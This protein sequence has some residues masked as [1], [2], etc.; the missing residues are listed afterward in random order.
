MQQELIDWQL[1]ID[2]TNATLHL[3]TNQGKALIRL[4]YNGNGDHDTALTTK[5]VL[6]KSNLPKAESVDWTSFAEQIPLPPPIVISGIPPIENWTESMLDWTSLISLLI[7]LSVWIPMIKSRTRSPIYRHLLVLSAFNFIIAVS[8]I[9]ISEAHSNNLDYPDAMGVAVALAVYLTLTYLLGFVGVVFQ[10]QHD[11]VFLTNYR[12]TALRIAGFPV[13]LFTLLISLAN[14]PANLREVGFCLFLHLAFLVA[15][16]YT[17]YR[18]SRQSESSN[19]WWFGA[20]VLALLIATAWISFWFKWIPISWFTPL[21]LVPE[22]ERIDTLFGHSC[23]CGSCW[24]SLSFLAPFGTVPLR[25]MVTLNALLGLVNIWM[26]YTLARSTFKSRLPAALFSGLIL[27]LPFFRITAFSDFPSQFLWFITFSWAHLIH[28][29]Q[30]VGHPKKARNLWATLCLL[31]T[32]VLLFQIRRE[33]VLFPTCALCVIAGAWVLNQNP[34]QQH[35]TRIRQSLGKKTH[36]G[37]EALHLLAIALL[38]S[39]LYVL[40]NLFHTQLAG[41]VDLVTNRDNSVYL[42]LLRTLDPKAVPSLSAFDILTCLFPIGFALFIILGTAIALFQYKRWLLLPLPFL[43]LLRLYA[44]A[45]WRHDHHTMR[46]ASMLMALMILFGLTGWAFLNERLKRFLPARLRLALLCLMILTGLLGFPD[47]HRTLES[48]VP[49]APSLTPY[50]NDCLTLNADLQYTTR[51]LLHMSEKNNT[52][53]WVS[54]VRRENIKTSAV[55]LGWRFWGLRN[56]SPVPLDVSQLPQMAKSDHCLLYLQ[57]PT[58]PTSRLHSWQAACLTPLDS[59]AFP[60][61]PYGGATRG[62]SPS[63]TQKVKELGVFRV[64]TS[65]EDCLNLPDLAD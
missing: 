45:G 20:L 31:L 46:L 64:D 15:I 18:Y 22:W 39:A 26:F 27:T 23:H 8:T 50:H 4:H 12:Y 58:S 11:S 21:Q 57:M 17:S 3:I 19:R 44:I 36:L 25:L 32:A 43:F 5:L 47:R 1:N 53:Y 13:L 55:T 52:C 61:R 14:V 35:I 29:W 51:L 30:P 59:L 56:R 41:L 24:T 2:E 42:W 34:I 63:P 54:P 16:F 62:L 49:V 7:L 38:V 10:R 33:L 6:D 48:D 60:S 65:T 40:W 28:R 37:D 9:S